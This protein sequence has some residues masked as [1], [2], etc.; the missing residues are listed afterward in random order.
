MELEAL[1][2]AVLKTKD[3][4][5]RELNKYSDSVAVS[6]VDNKAKEFIMKAITIRRKA[7]A[8]IL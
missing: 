2:K 5:V 4:N 6:N 1:K 3:M 8:N 7:I